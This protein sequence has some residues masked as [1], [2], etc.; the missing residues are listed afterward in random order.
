MEE[1]WKWLERF[2]WIAAIVSILKE[3][4]NTM[5]TV[6]Q[7]WDNLTPWQFLFLLSVIVII[8]NFVRNHIKLQKFKNREYEA[9]HEWLISKRHSGYPDMSEKSLEGKIVSMLEWWDDRKKT[10]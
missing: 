9:F 5:S 2:A 10:G 3:W 4:W 1:F 7:F 8:F 6:K